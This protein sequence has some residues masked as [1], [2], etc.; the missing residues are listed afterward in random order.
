MPPH[1]SRYLHTGNNRMSEEDRQRLLLCTALIGVT[2]QK[3]GLPP[4]HA[5]SLEVE[6]P[7][8][9][10][11]V[12][13]Y[14]IKDAALF[15]NEA[16]PWDRLHEDQD[17]ARRLDNLLKS[18]YQYRSATPE[19][20]R[21]LVD[22]LYF[23]ESGSGGTC[24]TPPPLRRLIAALAAQRPAKRVNDL[25]SG[26]GLLGLQVCKKLGGQPSY[27]GG[28]QNAYLCALSRLLLFLSGVEDF[29]VRAGDA[30][31]WHREEN[32]PMGVYVADLPLVGSRTVPV[33]EDCQR[34]AGD[35]PSL[36]FDWALIWNV[37]AQMR[38]GERAFFV[39]T[40]GALVRKNEAELRRQLVKRNLIDAVIALPAGMYPS[41]GLPTALLVCEKG[42]ARTEQVLFVDLED[43][44]VSGGRRTADLSQGTIEEVCRLFDR[45]AQEEAALPFREAVPR[46]GSLNPA[47]YLSQA[48]PAGRQVR[49]GDVAAVARGLQLTRYQLDGQGPCCLLNV[50]DIQDGEI[51]YESAERIGR[52]TATWEERYRVREDD[53]ILTSRGTALRMVIVP[54]GPP[55]AYISGNL[56]ILRADP[57]RYHPYLLYAYLCSEAG[58]A[59]L[60]LIQTGTT[61]R[62]LG[63]TALEGLLI[64]DGDPALMEARGRALKDLTLRHRAELQTLTETYQAQRCA[65]LE[66]IYDREESD[67]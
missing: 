3:F 50:R 42:R 59:A 52:G 8:L 56:T 7:E 22:D 19:W 47:L 30:A 20:L 10:S 29:S 2:R 66:G 41:H 65:L 16:T 4:D 39:V 13:G 5:K 34:L 33:E 23:Y 35:R 67:T 32:A 40:N 9:F 45:R 54:P 55:H 26:T 14:E 18:L 49:L 51:C 64:P 6:L 46:E 38:S 53:I 62:V 31:G 57:R 27:R 17:L 58:L 24:A 25:C 61:I 28:E 43:C 60:S 48:H 21:E 36:Y 37:L 44:A 1:L 11:R 63:V 12:P 15:F